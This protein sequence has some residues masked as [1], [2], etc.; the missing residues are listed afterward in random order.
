MQFLTLENQLR[1]GIVVVFACKLKY[2]FS[3]QAINV[4]SGQF[5]FQANLVRTCNIGTTSSN[6]PFNET[7]TFLIPVHFVITKLFLIGNI[8]FYLFVKLNT[9]IQ[10]YRRSIRFCWIRKYF[11]KIRI[12]CYFRLH[13]KSAKCKQRL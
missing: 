13:V 10:L 1:C 6:G 2:V 9:S 5:Q 4:D 11:L 8:Q 12:L 3:Y 7:T